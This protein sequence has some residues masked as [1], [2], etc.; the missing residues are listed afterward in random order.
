M[1]DRIVQGRHALG[2]ELQFSL[3]LTIMTLWATKG[4]SNP[5]SF[6]LPIDSEETSNLC[7]L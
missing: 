2:L 5:K 7:D 6:D 3:Q 4:T 1:D